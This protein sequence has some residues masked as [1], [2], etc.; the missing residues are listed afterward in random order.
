L[1]LSFAEIVNLETI[2]IQINQSH[3]ERGTVARKALRSVFALGIR[4]VLNQGMALTGGI[5]LAR[6][7]SPSEFGLY[8][9]ITF[10]LTF[11]VAFGDV[12]FA[13]SLV[14]Q[15]HEPDDE[16]YRAVFTVQQMMVGCVIVLFWICA[17]WFTSVYHL[18][19]HDRW[20][21]RLVALSL[22]CTSFQ[23]IPS[24]RL[25]RHLLFDKLA[26][27]E[28]A[29]SFVFYGTSVTLAWKGVGALSFAIA[30][31]ARSLTGAVLINFISPWRLRWHWDWER[32]RVHLKYG[33]FYQGIQL[34]SLVTSSFTPIYIGLLLGTAAV[35]YVNW[36]QMVSGYAVAGLMVLQRVY[37]PAFAR[38]QLQREELSKF[39]EQVIRSANAL[40]APVAMLTFISIVPL[41]K[42][43]FGPKWLPAIPLF[44]LLWGTN[45]F[46]PTATPVFA[47]LNALGHSRTAFKYSLAVMIGTW[48][49]GVPLIL[50][51]G[52][53]G[54]GIAALCVNALNLILY[55]VAQSHLRF[56][57]LPKV[58]PVWAIAFAVALPTYLLMRIRPPAGAMELTIYG[59]LAMSIY[60]LVFLLKYRSDVGK[61]WRLAT[62]QILG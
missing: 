38:L 28:V 33:I 40:A 58:A 45:I 32:A 15:P 59:T 18:P 30:I 35:G 14:R 41:A 48:V 4:Q 11:L 5:F 43:V 2:N 42:F 56:Q 26:V 8:A 16:D 61:V 52:M 49:L 51:F 1:D 10:L 13:A 55:R 23:V 17:P 19:Q 57:I 7:L 46:V 29:M 50:A 60:A 25:E 24:A 39:L 12:G 47:L 22:L 20:V 9:I 62:G 36:A 44:Y 53:I 34:I 3:V 6:L 54:Y 31:F 37:L 27:V 21:F